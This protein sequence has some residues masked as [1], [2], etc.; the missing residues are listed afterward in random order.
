MACGADTPPILTVQPAQ[1]RCAIR[2]DPQIVSL[3]HTQGFAKWD[4]ENMMLL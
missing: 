2:K 3:F 1:T 4:L